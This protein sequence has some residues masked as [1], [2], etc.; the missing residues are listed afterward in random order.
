V[1]VA[2]RRGEA[3]TTAQT[4]APHTKSMERGL[5]QALLGSFRG[6]DGLNGNGF[7]L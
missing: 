4:K 2:R 3:Q 1:R 6:G 7:P 5:D